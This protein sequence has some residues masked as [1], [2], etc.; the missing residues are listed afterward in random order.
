MANRLKL[1]IISAHARQYEVAQ[2]AQMT[3]TR[4]SRLVTGRE[5]ATADERK[6]L[7]DALGVPENVLFP[8]AA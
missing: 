1:A 5:Q 3:E 6:R 4:L 7:A 2:R 8:T